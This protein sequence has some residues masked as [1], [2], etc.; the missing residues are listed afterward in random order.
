MKLRTRTS[1]SETEE[2]KTEKPLITPWEPPCAT[3]VAL[4]RQKKERKKKKEI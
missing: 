4:K 1:S 2:K 3:G